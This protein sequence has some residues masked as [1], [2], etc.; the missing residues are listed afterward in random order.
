MTVST[1]RRYDSTGRRAKAAQN[2][3]QIISTAGRL[4]TEN[5]YERTTI[6][7]IAAA[8]GVSTATIYAQ[9]QNKLTLVE[10]WLKA[11]TADEENRTATEQDWFLELRA[12]DDFETGLHVF[13]H[14]V[15]GILERVHATYALVREV[16][17]S[18]PAVK[19]LYKEMSRDRLKG[20]TLAAGILTGLAP[21][22]P[23]D[24]VET[25]GQFLWAM[26]SPSLYNSL[27]TGSAA[28]PEDELYRPWTHEQYCDHLVRMIRAVYGVPE[29]VRD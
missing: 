24:S 9:F 4:F 1:T 14:G 27:V 21:A 15:C 26:V 18:D 6:A 12:A 29:V 2:G 13:V 7:A 23:R 16:G 8:A 10:E 22:P 25:L 20:L 17:R 5:G 19:A 3:A 11:V 28:E